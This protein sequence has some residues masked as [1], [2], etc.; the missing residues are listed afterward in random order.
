MTPEELH[1]E[2]RK[3]LL[4]AVDPVYRE[5]SYRYFK[6]EIDNYGV[7]T[8]EVRKIAGAAYK[9]WKR[10]SLSGRDEL[11][12]LLWQSGKLEEG[13]VAIVL[14]SKVAKEAG[15]REFRLYESW[16]DSYVRNWAHC[17]G[18]S[19]WLLAGCIANEPELSENLPAWTH[20]PNRW[21]KRAAAV[22][23]LWEGKTGRQL[24]R[25]FEVTDLLL[26]DH[27]DM[28]QKGAGWLLKETYPGR[29]EAVMEFL[30]PR[31]ERPTRTLLRYAAEKMS[32]ADREL[33]L[34]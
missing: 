11:C 29:P 25:V 26:D 9:H 31:R 32:A 27:D 8:P 3:H 6:E 2:T 18:V 17:D 1:L 28:V 15:A 7:R 4:A 12:E 13:S 24:D 33:L 21:K 10:W 34:S 16:I 5:G 20:S 30:M 14:H 22:G 19:T 23:L